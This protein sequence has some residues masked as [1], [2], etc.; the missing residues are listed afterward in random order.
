M[1]ESK[2]VTYGDHILRTDFPIIKTLINALDIKVLF[3]IR[4]LKNTIWVFN[5][6]IFLILQ[7]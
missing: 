7:T 1:T 5:L 4:K 3:T 6:I 2:A